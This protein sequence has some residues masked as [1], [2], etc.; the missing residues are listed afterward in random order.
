[1]LI[2]LADLQTISGE[3]QKCSGPGATE[4]PIKTY[5]RCR[6]VPRDL[7]AARHRSDAPPCL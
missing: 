5:G 2:R 7:G 6:L 4:Y 1:M 3:C